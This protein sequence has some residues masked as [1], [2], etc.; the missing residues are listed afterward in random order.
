MLLKQGA[1]CVTYVANALSDRRPC[2]LCSG[3]HNIWHRQPLKSLVGCGDTGC[4]AQGRHSGE[5]SHS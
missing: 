4:G 1:A 5:A 2:Q 3:Q